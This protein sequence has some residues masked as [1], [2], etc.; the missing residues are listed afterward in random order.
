MSGS[1]QCNSASSW[2]RFYPFVRRFAA[3]GLC[4]DPS[5]RQKLSEVSHHLRGRA[6]IKTWEIEPEVPISAGS[7][8]AGSISAH[9]IAARSITRGAVNFATIRSRS[10]SITCGAGASAAKQSSASEQTSAGSGKHFLIGHV[11]QES[12]LWA[13]S[14]AGPVSI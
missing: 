12:A 2:R 3:L 4:A 9:S 13:A 1:P 6:K 8:S 14:H 5:A 7:I 10:G 11:G